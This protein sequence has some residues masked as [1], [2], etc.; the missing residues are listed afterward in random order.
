M[1]L[2]KQAMDIKEAL[3]HSLEKSGLTGALQLISNHLYSFYWWP[4]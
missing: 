4:K 3:E 2:Q 1:G